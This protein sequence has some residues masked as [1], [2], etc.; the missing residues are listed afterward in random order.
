VTRKVYDST[1]VRDIPETVERDALVAGYVDGE[2]VTYPDLARLFPRHG[3]ISIT[4]TGR[5]SA[6]AIDCEA[7]DV[8]PDHA[9]QWA[10][11]EHHAGR[12]PTIYTMESQWE[13]CKERV[14]AH[15]LNPEHDVSWWIAWYGHD[16]IPDGA[17]ACQ[18]VRGTARA[19]WDRSD[20]RDYWAGVD[21]PAKHHPAP[22]PAPAHH[23]P[24]W[25]EHMIETLPTLRL[26]AHS[27]DVATWQGLLVARGFHHVDVDSV[28]GHTTEEATKALQE[29]E[30]VSNDGVVGRDT[31]TV[32]ITGRKA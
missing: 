17:V 5:L 6:N 25:T 18:N 31:W 14:R 19:H 10:A 20:A 16:G 4:V 26:G 28:F 23:Q 3:R 7:G 21:G 11:L 24:N 13:A 9:A 22:A 27:H 8:S 12:H 2:F 32:G 15:G 29:R 30:G 1:V